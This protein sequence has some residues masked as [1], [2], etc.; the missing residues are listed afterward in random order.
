MPSPEDGADQFQE[1]TRFDPEIFGDTEQIQPHGRR[2]RANPGAGI[3]PLTQRNADHRHQHHIEAG[4]EPCL[5]G[6]CILQANLLQRGGDKQ[7]APGQQ[8][9]L[10]QRYLARPLHHW[11][12]R[13]SQDQGQKTEPPQEK[14]DTI[15][16]VRAHVIHAHPLGNKAKAPDQRNQEQQDIGLNRLLF[17]SMHSFTMEPLY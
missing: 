17:F 10:D 16:G 6:C 1:V 5:A 4:N 3:G 12:V 9:G 14:A 13:P 2:N 15:E 7:D 8:S 11:R